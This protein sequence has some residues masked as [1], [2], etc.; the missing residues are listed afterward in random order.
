[1]KYYECK[2]CGNVMVLFEDAGVIP[3]CCGS[4]MLELLPQ[5]LDGAKEKHVPIIERNGNEV[6]VTVG[7]ILHPMVDEHYIKWIVLETNKGKYIRSL[8]PG[9]D[10]IAKFWVSDDETPLMAYEF[11]NLHSLWIG[12]YEEK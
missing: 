6:T 3:V 2:T 11:C 5:E 8:R 10:P 1:M 4:T 7:D 12:K 9:K